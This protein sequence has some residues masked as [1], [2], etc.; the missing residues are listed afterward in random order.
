M[1]RFDGIRHE[2]VSIAT[3]EVYPHITGMLKDAG[4]VDDKWYTEESRERGS[5]VHRLTADYDLGSFE[6]EDL[7]QIDSLY[8][9]WLSAHV[10]AMEK[11]K[12]TWTK[13]EEPLVHPVYRYGGR[14]DRVGEVY[15]AVAVLEIK[16]GGIEAAHA[17]QLAL[18]ALL[19]AEDVGL[20][21]ETI[22]RY[23]LYLKR[24]GRWTLQRFPNRA[25]FNQARRIIK[26]CCP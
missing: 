4:L 2:Y 13:V 3:G 26:L 10:D 5:C 11:I 8:K 7:A 21:A 14:C 24:T 20:P 19:V 18:Q 25:D 1:F 9:G 16:T 23:A 15:G 12:P 17:V 6:R 22:Q